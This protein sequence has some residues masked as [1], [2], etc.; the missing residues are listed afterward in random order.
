MKSKTS[1][2]S[3]ALF[4][5]NTSR[6]APLWG[7]FLGVLL[8]SGPVAIL[9]LNQRVYLNYIPNLWEEFFHLQRVLV[10]LYNAAYALLCA[11]L[12]FRYLHTPRSAYMMHAF[13]LSRKAQY[14]TNVLSG[15][16]FA[17]VPYLLQFA[18]NYLAAIGFQGA[19]CLP[20]L[21]AVE[22]LSFLFFFG[23]AVLCMLISGNT[24][25]AVL[26]Y[27]A[28]NFIFAAIP[29]LVLL[30]LQSLVFGFDISLHEQTL[31][32]LAP[33]VQMIRGVGNDG[34]I[35]RL[36]FLIYGAVGAL[37][38]VLSWL[39]YRVRQIEQAGE[40]MAHKWARVA[41][42]LVFTLG[43]TLGLGLILTTL[44]TGS[45]TGR[46][47]FPTLL[48]CFALAALIGWFAA[49][50]MLKRTVKVFHKRTWLGWAIF[51]GVV[52]VLLCA[53]RFDVLG[54]QRYVPAQADVKEL[55]VGMSTDNYWYDYRGAGDHADLDAN[56]LVTNEQDLAVLREMHR[57]A[58]RTWQQ[59]DE[60]YGPTV[61]CRYTLQNG[62]TV[63]RK[64]SLADGD[65]Q[66]LADLFSR[67]EYVTAYYQNLFAQLDQ[68]AMSSERSVILENWASDES[69]ICSDK[70]AV[71]EAVLADAVEGNLGFLPYYYG[72]SADDQWCIRYNGAS[73]RIGADAAHTLALFTEKL[74]PEG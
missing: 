18:L 1:L 33:M 22:L 68:N 53:V 74:T 4:C 26:S 34:T 37:L 41:F 47:V 31:V 63:V 55:T 64:F 23:L 12:L 21:L 67:P 71:R 44:F 25:I 61:T 45:M 62:R 48:V 28:L 3:S 50:M 60:L 13:P 69:A 30:V 24:A 14:T 70:A 6:F 27:A 11:A 72:G 9:N 42:Q 17:A 57:N 59:G 66:R 58:Q 20:R 10:V 38:L 54:F 8:L 46:A 43:C 40:A 16:C 39:H 49:Q 2:F 32:Y 51:A 5:K 65:V 29:A 15:L 52:A 7:I 36:P 19:D 56:I 35:A 73:I